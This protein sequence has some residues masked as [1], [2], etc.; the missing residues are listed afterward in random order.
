MLKKLVLTFAMALAATSVS[1]ASLEALQ[2]AWTI[3]GTD[4]SAT[5]TKAGG[6]V[7]FKN[8]GSEVSTGVIVTGNKIVS[9]DMTCTVQNIR[10]VKGRLSAR[11]SCADALLIQSMSMSF[12]ITGKD[13]FEKFDSNYPKM[14]FTYR[15]CRL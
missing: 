13:S 2:G 6:K 10:P 4:C 3:E 12:R 9:P 5:F 8:K 11:M 14:S 15:R 1:A 7:N